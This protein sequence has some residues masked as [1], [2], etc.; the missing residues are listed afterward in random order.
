MDRGGGTEGELISSR[1]KLK[2]TAAGAQEKKDCLR[3]LGKTTHYE[4]EKRK[5]KR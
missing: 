5:I 3:L 1:P 2:N 4:R